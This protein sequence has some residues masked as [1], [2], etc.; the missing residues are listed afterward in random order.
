M[1][2]LLIIFG[3]T[4]V[5][6]GL[7]LNKKTLED[8]DFAPTMWGVDLRTLGMVAGGAAW[9]LGGPLV[10]AGGVALASSSVLS[11]DLGKKVK[12]GVNELVKGMVDA[13]LKQRG[14]LDASSAP[15]QLPGPVAEM[16]QPEQP[17]QPGLL[18]QLYQDFVSPP[19]SPVPG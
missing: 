11:L 14:L 17:E 7:Y 6:S 8:E 19:P 2:P 4:S 5:G 10:A 3:L 12:M 9:L 1:N 16:P 15:L 13:Q 18:T